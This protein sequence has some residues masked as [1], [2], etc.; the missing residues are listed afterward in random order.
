[1]RMGLA[2]NPRDA[3]KVLIFIALGAFAIMV[4]VWSF[5][6]TENTIRASKEEIERTWPGTYVPP[7]PTR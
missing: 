2:K 1:M 7:R 6:G 3:A 5:S 4:A